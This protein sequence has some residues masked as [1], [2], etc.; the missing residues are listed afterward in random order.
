M[1]TFLFIHGWATD[2]WVW[3]AQ[4]ATLS[5]GGVSSVGLNLPGH[6]SPVVWDTP[7]LAPA[8][9]ETEKELEKHPDRSVVGVGWS[10]GGE[11]LLG[12]GPEIKKKLMGIVLVGAT[13]C[14][15][16]KDDFPHGQ[17]RAL[18]RRMIMDMKSDPGAATSRFLRLNFTE[19][20]L[21]RKEVGEF[22][23][24][25]RYPGPVECTTGGEGSPPGC[26]PLLRY[27]EVTRALEALYTTDLRGALGDV[28][29]PAL[30]I[31]G[32]ADSVCPVEAGK[33]LAENLKDAELKL[34]EGAG[35]APFIT[36]PERFA[37]LVREFT[38]NL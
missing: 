28:D 2:S 34:F 11:V 29:V 3:E 30:V 5:G 23:D 1:T 13:P 36:E 12:L 7:D 15:V 25:Y 22:L 21:E 26:Y 20:E 4:A 9:K 33:Y 14:F 32:T 18:T 35:H 10:L 27:G 37:E 8:I 19:G 38:K 24:R 17:S 16:A 31:H 6:G